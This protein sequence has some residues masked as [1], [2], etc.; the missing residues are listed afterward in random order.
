VSPNPAN[1]QTGGQQT[2]TAQG[3]DQNGQPMS[4]TFAWSATGGTIDQ[5][6]NYAAGPTAGTFSVTATSGGVQGS[7]TVNIASA[8]PNQILTTIVVTPNPASTTTGGTVA[9]TAQGK[10]QNGNTMSATFNWMTSAGTIDQSGKYTA[11]NAT[12]SFDVS[13][14]SQG[15]VGHATVN[16][17][18]PGATLIV[19]DSDPAWSVVSGT[20]N[21]HFNAYY[22]GPTDHLIAT[23]TAGVCQW[24]P[25]LPSGTYD[26]YVWTPALAG[27]ANAVY[28]ITTATG[29]V[30]VSFDQTNQSAWG[31]FTKIG[32]WSLSNATVV[33]KL[34]ANAGQN[35]AADAVKFVQTGP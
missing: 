26:V 11:P 22:Y 12:G 35:V 1:L 17:S 33:L 32:T 7:A 23:G 24:K 25:S 28:T 16:V 5:S 29:D 4:A 8:P 20:W 6:G 34:T 14:S 27:P 9:F 2:F 21:R 10:D 13:A 31:T 18:A 3:K 15:I 19:D 30:T